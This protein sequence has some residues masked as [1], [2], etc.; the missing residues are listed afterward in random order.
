MLGK[1]QDSADN[2]QW[3]ES[4][5]LEL[6]KAIYLQDVE[7]PSMIDFEDIQLQEEGEGQNIKPIE[8]KMRW[9]ILL[10]GLGGMMPG[11][12]Y[13]VR[14]LAAKMIRDIETK[15]ERYVPWKDQASASGGQR[16]GRNQYID[17]VDFYR[18][19]FRK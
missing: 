12:R 18:K 11:Q 8:M 16:N 9:C 6:L 13:V 1:T 2:H 19:L 14:E 3:S 10:K 5:D 4:D 15:H 17:I 7:D